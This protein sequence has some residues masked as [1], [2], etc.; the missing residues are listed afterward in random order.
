[1]RNNREPDFETLKKIAGY[2]HVSIDFLLSYSMD[3][4]HPD[5][6][7]AQPCCWRVAPQQS[8]FPRPAAYQNYYFFIE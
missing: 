8:P 3:N 2:F 7:L 6:V 1:V 5:P 4:K